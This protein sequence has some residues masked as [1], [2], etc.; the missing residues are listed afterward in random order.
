MKDRGS[1]TVS[2]LLAN[3]EPLKYK[4][5]IELIESEFDNETGNIAFRASFPNS[6]KLLRNGETGQVQMLVPL[7]NAIVIPQ[8]ATYEIQ[9]KKYVFVVDSSNK[10]SSREITITGEIPDLYVITSGITANDKI[11]LDGVQ[12]VKESDKIS[13]GY[14]APQK[15]I[16]NLRLKAE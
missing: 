15:V 4:G 9:D 1:N 11:L 7:K 2:L 8:K 5:K 3:G 12:K 6:D 13:Y 16:K 10:V 14:I